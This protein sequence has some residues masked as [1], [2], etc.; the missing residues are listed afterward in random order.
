M[1]VL[2][3]RLAGGWRSATRG[4]LIYI[5]MASAFCG[6]V[7]VAAVRGSIGVALVATIVAVVTLG[8]AAIAPRLS[9]ARGSG[10]TEEL[11]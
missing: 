8:L 2:V 11:R 6:L 4:R 5:V 10:D 7:V 3:R 1:I 9:A